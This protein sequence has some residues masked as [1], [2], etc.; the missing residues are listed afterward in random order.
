MAYKYLTASRRVIDRKGSKP[1]NDYI[2]LFQETLNSQ[3]Y[4]SSDWWT[5]QEETSLGSQVYRDI[6][7]RI[8]HVINAET[9]LK[10]G[11][12]WK[13]VLFKDID[14]NIELGKQYNFDSNIWLTIN[15]EIIKNLTGT[16]TIR[17]CNNT[18]RWIDEATGA[19]YE[20]PCALEYLVKEPRNYATAGSPFMTP[21][22]FLHATLQF[23]TRTN[24]IKENQRFLFGNPEH[25]TCYKVVGTGLNDFRNLQTSNNDS[26]R[27]LSID[28]TADFVNDE[29]DD[30]INGIADVVT[31][32]YTLTLDRTT[33]EGAPNDTLQ[34]TASVTYNESSVTRT[35]VWETS[36]SSVATV[37]SNGLVS[38]IA[39]G[40]CV[41]TASISNNPVSDTCAVSCSLAPALNN[42]VVITPN[43][44]FILESGT[45][46]YSVFLYENNVLLPDIF[47][48]TC[49]GN[50]VPAANY[51]FTQTG[52]N[53]FTIT[54]KL[55]DVSSYLT[56][57]C[58]SGVNTKVF[59]I[60]LRGGW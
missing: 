51:V 17:R 3:F 22:G 6:D 45:Q 33:T 2:S 15:T 8:T 56:V 43:T 16:C 48:I 54:N 30:I 18:L 60:Y 58:V 29:L 28:L 39:V 27:I 11:D 5:V 53:E 35:I 49:N 34:L 23:N 41:I 21:G 55:R 9:G 31:N 4:N 37:D 13:T 47:T 12:D 57:T 14:H 40:S 36:N 52:D 10:L 1:K 46:V 38:F 59:N 44:N 32:A 26:A 19:Y 50:S 42:D 25:W 20:E 7:V 24:K